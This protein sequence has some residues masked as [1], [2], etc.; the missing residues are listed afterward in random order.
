MRSIAVVGA[1]VSGL[2]AAK[3]LGGS[4]KVVLYE[5]EARLGGHAR[6]IE[7]PGRMASMLEPVA[8]DTGFIVYNEVNYPRLTALFAELG[9]ATIPT[10]MSFGIS[11][12]GLN[13]TSLGG[14]FAQPRNLASPTY[15]AMLRDVSRFF[16]RATEVLR[17]AD[18]PSLGEWLEELAIGQLARDRFI[19][20]MG[21]AIWSTPPG[22]LVDM[23]AKTFVRFFKNHNL[24][25][26]TGHHAWRTV[27]GGSRRYVDALA[28]ALARQGVEVRAAVP[29]RAIEATPDGRH[30]VVTAD[31][32]RDA[33]DE[34]VLACHADA[35]LTLIDAPT[36]GERAV[37]SAFAFRDNH[38][39]LHRDI[40]VMPKARAAW[41]SWVFTAED[42][43]ATQGLSVTYWMNRLQSLAGPPLLVTLNPIRPIA[44]DMVLDRHTFRHPMLTR[45]AVEAQARLPEVQG[46]RGLWFAG[47]WT[48][49][50]FHEDGLESAAWV[51]DTIAARARAVET[52]TRPLA[53]EAGLPCG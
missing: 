26:A 6:T 20:P 47:A 52:D 19:I 42:A 50:G 15:W 27:A 31:G 34:V 3:L 45:A 5:K 18:D 46:R 39:V 7:V 37:L 53:A 35:A 25:S 2:G 22:D 12:G 32:H 17:S 40:R 41:A 44:E 38:A 13:G 4:G 43:A 29:V 48:R 51:A 33:F 10:D 23:P 9:V 14:L 1:G 11:V 16:R 8:V 28:E 49:Y 24:L 30:V 21:A 36:A